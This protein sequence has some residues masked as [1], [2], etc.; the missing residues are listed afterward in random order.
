M[1]ICYRVSLQKTFCNW[2]VSTN[3]AV[4]YTSSFT[5][6]CLPDQSFSGDRAGW[7]AKMARIVYWKL[8]LLIF[9]ERRRRLFLFC[10][11]FYFFYDTILATNKWKQVMVW[12]GARSAPLDPGESLGWWSVPTFNVQEIRLAGIKFVWKCLSELSFWTVQF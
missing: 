11:P 8:C 3:G 6:I 5:P 9:P 4:A 7:Q 12:L 10:L 2:N 1:F